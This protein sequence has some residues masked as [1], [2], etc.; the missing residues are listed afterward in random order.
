MRE[1][2]FSSLS[3]F[4]RDGFCSITAKRCL[5]A[6]SVESTAKTIHLFL[7]YGIEHLTGSLPQIKRDINNCL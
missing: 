5:H 6:T 4:E 1:A 3:V 2:I 7:K